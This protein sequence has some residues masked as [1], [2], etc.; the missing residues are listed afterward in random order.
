MLGTIRAFILRHPFALWA[1]IAVVGAVALYTYD[2]STN[3]PGFFIDES[4]IAY[5]AHVI[6]QT[7]RDEFGNSWPLFFRAFGEYKNPIYVYLLAGLFRVT[8]PGMFVARLLSATAG[9]ATAV[10]LGRLAM[11]IS[12]RRQVG[13]LVA[14]MALFTPLLFELSRM[15]LEVALYPLV[16]ALFLLALWRASQKLLWGWQETAT[17]A[18]TLAL[19]TYTY[20]IGRLLGPLLALGLFGFFTRAR[21]RWL[22]MTLSA[23]AV[24]L[25]PML[26]VRWRH[27]E[28][29]TARFKYLTYIV[30]GSS[31]PEIS[32]EFVKH[33][34]ANLNPWRL[35][36][37]EQSKANELIHLPGAPAMLA[38]TGV[39]MLAGI[40]LIFYR[41]QASRWSAF[42]IYGLLVSVVPASLTRETFHLLRLSPLPV[43]IIVLTIPAFVWLAEQRTTV[44]R[45][46]FVIVVLL[47]LS[48]AVVFQVKY[49]ASAQSPQRLHSFDAD[50]PA[51]IL[52][53][54]LAAAGAAPVYLA[55]NPARPGYIQAYWYATLQAIPLSKFVSLG[56]DKSAAERA[57]VITTEESCTRC[58]VLTQSEPYTVYVA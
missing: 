40:I 57:V 9:V 26:V 35:F 37:G 30:P 43:F 47:G 53:A 33:F 48:Q 25:A 44:G 7:G 42:I 12:G 11:R 38:I 29:L 46:V 13:L 6:A 16:V 56:V 1:S 28:V 22:L 45:L 8:G 49:H 21:W 39:L 2:L 31:A 34:V 3:P 32:R 52:P 20:S 23:Y 4:S 36:V 15:V 50:Y 55:D 17:L 19:I 5:N 14:L 24:L 18:V 27:P 10:I 41:H 51:K 58:R 54:A